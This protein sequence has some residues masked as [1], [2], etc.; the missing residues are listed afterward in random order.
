MFVRFAHRAANVLLWTARGPANHL[1]HI[2][3]EARRAH[4]VMRFVDGGVR[5]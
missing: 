1:C 3:F 4:A 5:I 2:L